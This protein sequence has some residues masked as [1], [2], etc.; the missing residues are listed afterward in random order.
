MYTGLPGTLGAF[1]PEFCV[2]VSAV[3]R[4]TVVSRN[5]RAAEKHRFLPVFCIAPQNFWK[6]KLC[7][8][9]PFW[10]LLPLVFA[11]FLRNRVFENFGR[12]EKPA[13]LLVFCVF[14]R[15]FKN[16]NFVAMPHFR[17]FS[18]PVFAIFL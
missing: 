1:G 9:A 6:S 18:P 7:R 13:I 11:T 12:R 15:I 16:P 8:D 2:R 3:F 14:S 10:V 5:L 17:V 4:Q